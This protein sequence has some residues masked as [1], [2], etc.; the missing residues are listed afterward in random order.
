[1]FAYTLDEWEL[2]IRRI[3]YSYAFFAINGMQTDGLIVK[4]GKRHRAPIAYQ[5]DTILTS[6]LMGHKTP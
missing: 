3:G 1:M 6:G 4:H 5:V 2:Y